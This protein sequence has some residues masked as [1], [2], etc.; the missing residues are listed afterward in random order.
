MADNK[1]SWTLLEGYVQKLFYSKDRKSYQS[2]FTSEWVV[3]AIAL[4]I[5]IVASLWK[6]VNTAYNPS[7]GTMNQVQVW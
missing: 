5:D 6:Q 4:D 2:V 7:L 3:T 1:S